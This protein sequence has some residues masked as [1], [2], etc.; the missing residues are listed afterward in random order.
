M[1]NR[2]SILRIKV[3]RKTEKSFNVHEWCV[4]VKISMNENY[5]RKTGTTD[6]RTTDNEQ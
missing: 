5:N 4:D 3:I 1:H 2:I 6:N